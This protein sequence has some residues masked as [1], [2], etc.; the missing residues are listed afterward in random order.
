MS[1]YA[2]SFEAVVDSLAYE[3]YNYTVVFVPPTIEMDAA[4][5]RIDG[6]IADY[7]FNAAVL[8]SQQGR[9]IILG[10]DLMRAAG[11]RIGDVVEVRFNIA[12]PDAVVVPEPLERA[13]DANEQAR[14]AWDALTP[15]R[16][17]KYWI[18]LSVT[19]SKRSSL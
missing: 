18:S 7:P 15:G 8:P 5:V 2:Y 9:H 4:R 6:E 1:Y 13:L 12:D 19:G 17:R 3:T 14:A 11:L 10:R 16:R